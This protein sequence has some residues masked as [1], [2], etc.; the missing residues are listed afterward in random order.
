MLCDYVHR[1]HY[2]PSKIHVNV[3]VLK[4]VLPFE[5]NSWIR[6]MVIVLFK[7]N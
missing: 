6:L 1:K 4:N 5:H 7:T 3:C 2:H